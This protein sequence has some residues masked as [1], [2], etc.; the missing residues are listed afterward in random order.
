[1]VALTFKLLSGVLWTLQDIQALAT[2]H[3]KW[4]EKDISGNSQQD[5]VVLNNRIY[6][7]TE[8]WKSMSKL[9]WCPMDPALS[10]QS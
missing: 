10:F 1:M 5:L 2:V 4:P 3:E 7:M 8:G 6:C 9:S